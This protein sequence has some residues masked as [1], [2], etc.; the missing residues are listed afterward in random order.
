M[1]HE[2]FLLYPLFM[3]ILKIVTFENV[4]LFKKFRGDIVC[5][6]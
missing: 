5:R 2:L 4:T 3:N 6:I 1:R